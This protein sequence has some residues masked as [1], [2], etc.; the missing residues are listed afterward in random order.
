MDAVEQLTGQ[1]PR[2]LNEWLYSEAAAAARALP[3]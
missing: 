1:E 2:A 3:D